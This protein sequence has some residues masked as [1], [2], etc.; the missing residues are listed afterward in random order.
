MH[1]SHIFIPKQIIFQEVWTYVTISSAKV[2]TPYLSK[3]INL[4][5]KLNSKRSSPTSL[6][7]EK[8]WAKIARFFIKC[9]NIMKTNQN[10]THNKIIKSDKPSDTLPKV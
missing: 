2:T 4:P 7:K 6:T 9:K 3:G 5:I 1:K 8:I 10:Q